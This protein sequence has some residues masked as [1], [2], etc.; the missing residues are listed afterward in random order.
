M[1]IRRVCIS[2]AA[3]RFS[4]VATD[5]ILLSTPSYIIANPHILLSY[6]NEAL[7]A[8]PAEDPC[9]TQQLGGSIQ[10]LELKDNWAKVG[11][12]TSFRLN[13]VPLGRRIRTPLAHPIRKCME[14]CIQC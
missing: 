14:F 11:L 12:V 4:M 5:S 9:S 1:V 7:R 13:K 8:I 3:S 10:D 2:L 6:C